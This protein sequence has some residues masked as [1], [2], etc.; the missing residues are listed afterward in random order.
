MAAAENSSEESCGPIFFR[1]QRDIRLKNASF[2]KGKDL[3]IT[4]IFL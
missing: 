4:I 3:Y 1:L 2:I